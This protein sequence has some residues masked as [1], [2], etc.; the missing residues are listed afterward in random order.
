MSLTIKQNWPLKAAMLHLLTELQH[1][2]LYR[3]TSDYLRIYKYMEI[4]SLHDQALHIQASS[5]HLP[6]EKY[7]IQFQHNTVISLLICSSPLIGI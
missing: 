1:M 7:S 6:P 4:G 5:G 2:P 3:M